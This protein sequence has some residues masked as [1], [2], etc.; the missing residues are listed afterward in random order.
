MHAGVPGPRPLGVLRRPAAHPVAARVDH[1]VAVALARLRLVRVVLEP[2]EDLLRCHPVSLLDARD[3]AV[4]GGDEPVEPGLLAAQLLAVPGQD[5]DGAGPALPLEHLRDGVQA[6]PEAAQQQDLLQAQQLGLAVPAQPALAAA[7]RA[8]QPDRVVVAQG[9]R[10]HAGLPGD[11]RD[12]PHA[13]APSVLAGSVPAGRTVGVDA[14]SSASPR[15]RSAHRARHRPRPGPLAQHERRGAG[16]QEGAPAPP[17]R[18]EPAAGREHE[19][20]E[21][22]LDEQGEHARQGEV[23]AVARRR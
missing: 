1:L 12:R 15:W 18:H 14:A 6:E 22:Q 17:Q 4:D 5:L 21:R 16:Q 11:L 8:E 19:G 10:G 2:L 7:G 9:P 23:A 20:G 13:A 3:G